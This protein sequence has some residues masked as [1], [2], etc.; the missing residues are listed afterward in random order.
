MSSTED[1]ELQ[2]RKALGIVPARK[3][4]T[5]DASRPVGGYLVVL[6]V[7][8]ASGPAFRFEHRSRSISRTE[9]ILAA[10]KQAKAQGLRPW[11]LLDVEQF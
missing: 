1:L 5:K 11:A 2:M 6:S 9:A 3:K 7:R 8:E 10:E 4:T